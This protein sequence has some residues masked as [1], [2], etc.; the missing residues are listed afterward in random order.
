MLGDGNQEIYTPD[1]VHIPRA[2]TTPGADNS[3]RLWISL[4][5]DELVNI[6]SAKNRERV[7]GAHL[8]WFIQ[9]EPQLE[10]LGTKP[11]YV[12][13]NWDG[14]GLSLPNGKELGR[15]VTK[16][17]L[18]RIASVRFGVQIFVRSHSP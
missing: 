11:F 5:M 13:V 18:V 8:A 6:S 9:H 7:G 4:W 14:D 2:D 12:P 1:K 15:L 10:F 16:S 3:R 17:L